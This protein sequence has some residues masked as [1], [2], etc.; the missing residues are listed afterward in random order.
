MDFIRYWRSR[1]PQEKE[2]FAKRAGTTM[3][4]MRT[5]VVASA[6]F[7]TLPLKKN[8]IRLWVATE[9]ECTLK[10][11]VEHFLGDLDGVK[12]SSEQLKMADLD[13]VDLGPFIKDQRVAG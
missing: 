11:V 1:T 3:S 10:E 9:G 7:R 12:P 5:H 6:K 13:V 8:L 2:A 4:H